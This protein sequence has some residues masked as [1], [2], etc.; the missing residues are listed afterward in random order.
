LLILNSDKVHY[1]KPLVL[2]LWEHAQRS[3]GKTLDIKRAI[4]PE[5]LGIDPADYYL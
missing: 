4:D 3:R 1:E 2:D 5:T